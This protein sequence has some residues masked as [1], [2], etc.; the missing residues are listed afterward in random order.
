M[1]FPFFKA[2]YEPHLIFL[3]V[4]FSIFQVFLRQSFFI[5]YHVAQ[6]VFFALQVLRS[7][8]SPLCQISPCRFLQLN[9]FAA[10][11]VGSNAHPFY[12]FD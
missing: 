7:A 9:S 5:L 2:V 3:A 11:F 10:K 6:C 4:F 12:D 1:T 8:A